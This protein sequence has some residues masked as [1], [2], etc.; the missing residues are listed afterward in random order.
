M[1]KTRKYLTES[2]IVVLG[3]IL[4]F[5][6]VKNSKRVEDRVLTIYT[7]QDIYYVDINTLTLKSELGL[8]QKYDSFKELSFDLERKSSEDVSYGDSY[9]INEQSVSGDS[10][11]MYKEIL[12]PY[13]PEIMELMEIRIL[14]QFPETTLQQ[15]ALGY[16]VD[17]FLFANTPEGSEFWNKV[18]I[19]HNFS[20]F[21]KKYP[22]K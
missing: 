4:L 17:L 16:P 2:I 6:I 22:K 14:Q 9:V 21:Y 15:M 7:A 11:W 12:V 13:P 8:L 3:V 1:S 10:W 18:L 20:V 19:E 5:M